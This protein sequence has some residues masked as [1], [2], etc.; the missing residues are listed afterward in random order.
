MSMGLDIPIETVLQTAP[1]SAKRRPACS[2]GRSLFVDTMG[3]VSVGVILGVG[4]E[5]NKSRCFLGADSRTP[6]K[7]AVAS[8]IDDR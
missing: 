5:S 7:V 1:L 6:Q 8:F 3:F 2:S 4:A